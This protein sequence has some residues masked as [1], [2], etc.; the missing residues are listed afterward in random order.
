MDLQNV[1]A[2]LFAL[3]LRMYS[4]KAIKLASSAIIPPPRPYS[5]VSVKGLNG[6]VVGL[7]VVLGVG[8]DDSRGSLLLDMVY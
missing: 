2:F 6:V 5:G 8:V 4:V 7:L 3:V 1:Y